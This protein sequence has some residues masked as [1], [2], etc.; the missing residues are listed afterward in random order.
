[1]ALA[2]IIAQDAPLVL[3]DEPTTA[4]DVGHE[5]LVMGVLQASTRQ[6]KAVVSVLHD[7]NAAAFHADRL[8]LIAGGT[9]RADGAPADVL[10][11]DVLSDVY[12]HPLR[13][14]PH[15]YRDCPLVLVTD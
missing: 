11:E 6:G 2:R 5:E 1:M 4:L 10:R 14:I 3:L 7:L 8:V 15:P 12:G 9:V 13:V